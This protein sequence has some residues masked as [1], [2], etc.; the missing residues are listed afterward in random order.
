[1]NTNIIFVQKNKIYNFEGTKRKFYNEIGALMH[2]RNKLENAKLLD[3]V[4][5]TPKKYHEDLVREFCKNVFILDHGLSFRTNVLG[6]EIKI[7]PRV[8]R[9]M[10]GLHLD[11]I[12]PKAGR[13]RELL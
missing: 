6:K 11:G 4:I 7:S 3:F 12:S 2:L 10:F 9:D 13:R 5:A 1:M 8:F